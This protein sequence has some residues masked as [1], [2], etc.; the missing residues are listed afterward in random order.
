MFDSTKHTVELVKFL[1]KVGSANSPTQ[2]WF[3]CKLLP[4]THLVGILVTELV[5]V[6]Y[7]SPTCYYTNIVT[8][9][10]YCV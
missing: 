1:R 9:N 3:L 2:N 7:C 4:V 10:N 5:H 8:N 6:L